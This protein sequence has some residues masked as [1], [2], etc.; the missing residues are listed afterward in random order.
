M[1]AQQ[2]H[3]GVG[4]FTEDKAAEQAIKGLESSGFP[5]E[6]VSVL[7]KQLE[8]DVVASGAKT[9]HQ[10]QGQDLNNPNRLPE[11]ALTTAFWGSLLVGLTSL[12]IPGAGAVIA[13]GSVGAAFATVAAGQGAGAAASFSLEGKLQS[14]GIP[15]Q[16]AAAFSDR[17]I[18]GDYMVIVDGHSEDLDRA[19]SVLTDHDIQAWDVYGIPED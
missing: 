5:M 4:F 11:T 8:S 14:L 9:G 13:A 19:E 16:Q 10:I 12:S 1:A 6:Q 2:T 18:N 15:Q 17:L 3:R 7:A